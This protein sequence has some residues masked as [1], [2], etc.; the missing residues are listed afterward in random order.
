MRKSDLLTDKIRPMYARYLVAATGSALVYS[1]FGI[2]DAA[3]IG[4]YHGPIGNAALAVFSPI[5]AV[6]YCLGLL[7]GVGGAVLF[8]NARGKGDEKSAQE[9]FSVTVLFGAILRMRNLLISFDDFAG[10][11]ILSERRSFLNGICRIT[12]A[13]IRISGMR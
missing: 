1:V 8:G 4:K 11:E 6:G 7:S 5:W 13:A 2:V 10:M 12:S 3:M 9:D